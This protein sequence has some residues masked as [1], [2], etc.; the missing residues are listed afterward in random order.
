MLLYVDDILLVS[1]NLARVAEIKK[2]L[3]A[4]FDLKDMGLAK[5][6][7]GIEIE[8][9]KNSISLCQSGFINGILARFNMFDCK[10][11]STPLATG[12]KLRPC[13]DLTPKLFPYREL[14]GALMYLS[15]GTRPEITHAVSYLSQFN[16]CH[17]NTHWTAA[18]HVLHYLKGTSNMKLVYSMDKKGL[19]GFA[20]ANWGSDITDR[21]SY[22]GYVFS[23]CNGAISWCSKKQKSVALSFSEAEYMSLSDAAKEAIFLS[24]LLKELGFA[25]LSRTIIYND[26]QSAGKLATNPYMPTEEMIADILTKALPKPKVNF[27]VN[28]LGLSREE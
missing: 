12:L 13:E 23:L 27:C 5:Y 24:S 28:G 15:V 1:R 4:S 25:D 7:L 17:D 22:S 16:S 11:V 3:T 18:K 2:G 21:K 19:R 8:Q 9:N 14:I 10:S 26:N 20:D 6:C